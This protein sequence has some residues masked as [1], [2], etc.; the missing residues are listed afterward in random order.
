MEEVIDHMNDTS[1]L[2]DIKSLLG[3]PVDVVDFDQVLIIHCNTVFSTL[4]QLGLGDSTGF[5]IVDSSWNWSDIIEGVV[6]LHNVKSYMY[7]KV[8][9][10]F[11]P[12]A[13]AT[14]LNSMEQQAQEIEWRIR[15]ELENAMGGAV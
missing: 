15:M 9:L 14:L 11:D 3:I 5:Y 12:P 6:N 1:I 8:K 10:L 13:N 4:T 2:N 7:L